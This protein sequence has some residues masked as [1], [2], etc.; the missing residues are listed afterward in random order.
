MSRR[1]LY[2][3]SRDELI[4]KARSMAVARAEVLTQAELIDEIVKR[5]SPRSRRAQVRGWLGRARDLVARVVEKGLH[6][7][8]AAKLFRA[9]PSRGRP[10]PPPPLPTVTLAEIYAAQS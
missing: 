7:P 5:T 6:L 1:D 4:E 8:E 2:K 9:P 10:L 3:M